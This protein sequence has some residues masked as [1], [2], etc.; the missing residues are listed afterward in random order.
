MNKDAKRSG[1]KEIIRNLY[2]YIVTLIGLLMI[3][4]PLIDLI[5]IGME[6]A[7]F[8]LARE[9]RYDYRTAPEPHFLGKTNVTESG[10]VKETI[11]L[12]EDEQD[13]F[14]RWKDEFDA[15]EEREKHTDWQAVELQKSLVQD[16]SYFIGGLILFIPH[17]LILWG[18]RKRRKR[19]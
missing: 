15:W 16:I 10:A 12:T 3:V 18:D 9:D 6:S 17:A 2:L 5:R 7:F 11:R 1:A 14:A 4:L 19:E 13:Q 8:P